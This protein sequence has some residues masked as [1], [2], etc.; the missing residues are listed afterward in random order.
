MQ[1]IRMFKEMAVE[2]LKD[3]L[4]AAYP[5]VRP[6]FDRNLVQRIVHQ[7]TGTEEAMFRPLNGKW[8]ITVSDKFFQG[9][10]QYGE[11]W[12]LYVLL[13]ECGHA[14][15]SDLGA[16]GKMALAA[17]FDVDL[18]DLPLAFQQPNMDEA[19]AETFAVLV[20]RD[21]R[22]L[23]LL[24]EHWPGWRGMVETMCERYGIRV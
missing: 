20:S 5:T 15:E 2:D 9:V 14:I 18:W 16:A 6:V 4:L 19:F 23:S 13:H 8:V 12:G 11:D 3:R 24:D 10:E 22:G 1:R 7:S 21:Q 17:E